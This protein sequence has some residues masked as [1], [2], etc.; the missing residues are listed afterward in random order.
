[1]VNVWWVPYCDVFPFH[2]NLIAD[3]MVVQNQNGIFHVMYGWFQSIGT[4]KPYKH[5]DDENNF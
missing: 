1:M 5:L 4:F 3:L 2:K